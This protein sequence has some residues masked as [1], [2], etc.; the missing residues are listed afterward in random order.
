MNNYTIISIAGK[1]GSGKT[2]LCNLITRLW[3]ARTKVFNLAEPLKQIGQAL[4]VDI[5]KDDY[6]YK[7]S[8]HMDCFLTYK[9]TPRQFYQKVGTGMRNH[10]SP[11]IF[12]DMLLKKV[13]DCTHNKPN[14]PTI[15]VVGDIRFP[16]EAKKLSQYGP[17]IELNRNTGITDSHE[18]EQLYLGVPTIKIDNNK[19]INYLFNE[20]LT[21]VVPVIDP[22]YFQKTYT[23]WITQDINEYTAISQYRDWDGIP[24]GVYIDIKY[25]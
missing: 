10:I 23:D 16:N 7:N 1:Q 17:I 9:I 12:I 5:S 4:G 19:D 15:I 11:D 18:S 13:H 2:T 8:H 3:G 20:F 21:N 22:I 24:S 25:K 6:T 14:A